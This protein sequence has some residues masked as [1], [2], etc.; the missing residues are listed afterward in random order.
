M[1]CVLFV[2]RRVVNILELNINISSTM[3][4]SDNKSIV[5][6]KASNILKVLKKL[7]LEYGFLSVFWVTLLTS[8]AI[9]IL[10][11]VN[12]ALIASNHGK[13]RGIREHVVG[14]PKCSDLSQRGLLPSYFSA[15]NGDTCT[16]HDANWQAVG[17]QKALEQLKNASTVIPNFSPDKALDL[18]EH[19]NS[20]YKK[21]FD[22]LYGTEEEE[23]LMECA[24]K[25]LKE[26]RGGSS[27]TCK[28]TPHIQKAIVGLSTSLT[29]MLAILMGMHFLNNGLDDIQNTTLYGFALII[30]LIVT[31]QVWGVTVKKFKS[32]GNQGPRGAYFGAGFCESEQWQLT[33]NHEYKLEVA[34]SDAMNLYI[35]CIGN[36][37][38]VIKDI[39]GM[40]YGSSAVLSLLGLVCI[41]FTMVRE[42][43]LQDAIWNVGTYTTVSSLLLI[44]ILTSVSTVIRNRETYL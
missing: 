38:V 44:G 4:A 41:L 19:G 11:V 35:S 15:L 14:E 5:L 34:E 26:L 7:I 17:L 36:D 1:H 30:S 2:K 39:V 33:N 20:E 32:F 6:Q 13:L 31:T 27:E 16:K 37:Q 40:K 21:R 42:E 24:Y 10:I 22:Q 25:Q 8:A 3:T 28:H 43:R 23:G 29:T 9:T 12:A 18:N